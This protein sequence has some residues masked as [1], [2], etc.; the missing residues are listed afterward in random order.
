M[1]IFFQLLADFKKDANG[2][3]APDAIANQGRVVQANQEPV[4]Q[5]NQKRLIQAN[6]KRLIQANQERLIQANQ[7]RLIQAN[8]DRV[9]RAL[10][11]EKE[12]RETRLSYAKQVAH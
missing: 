1:K 12:A 8:Q 10:I 4:I 7:E 2:P 9:I 6:Q 11:L 5:A 3:M